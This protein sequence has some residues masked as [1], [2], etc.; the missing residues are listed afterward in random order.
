[1]NTKAFWL[2]VLERAAKTAANSLLVMWAGDQGLDIM[3]VDVN[4]ALGLAGG[5]AA[6]SVLMSIASA[7]VN[8][9]GPSLATEAV[10]PTP[11]G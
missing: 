4:H 1:M 11:P 10:V 9:N 2:A 5:A 7:G 8:N 6:L 3:N